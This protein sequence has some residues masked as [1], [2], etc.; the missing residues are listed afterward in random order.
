MCCCPASGGRPIDPRAFPIGHQS[1]VPT[2]MTPER[3]QQINKLYH[4][5]LEYKPDQRAAFL[6]QAC[7][8][9]E[10]LR[11][12]L[13]SLLAQQAESLVETPALRWLADRSWRIEAH[14]W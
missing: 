14:H 8:G 9:D 11:H 10:G 6:K 3:W 4:S 5:A 13:E 1:I 7:A 2:L 12:E